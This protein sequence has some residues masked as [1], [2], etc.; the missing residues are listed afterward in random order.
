MRW[1]DLERAGM[2]ERGVGKTGREEGGYGVEELDRWKG[3]KQG[4]D[5]REGGRQK[6]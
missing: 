4:G 1:C 2:K 6:E 5:M 3:R